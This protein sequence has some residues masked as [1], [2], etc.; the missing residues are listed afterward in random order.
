MEIEKWALA[1]I[2]DCIIEAD[3][4]I[5]HK[6][7]MYSCDGCIGHGKRVL[8]DQYRAVQATVDANDNIHILNP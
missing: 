5:M 1:P 8:V 3:C 7:G 6:A 2:G 4:T